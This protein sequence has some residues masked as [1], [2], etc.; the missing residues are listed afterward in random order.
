MIATK[1]EIKGAD[2]LHR[3]LLQLQKPSAIKAVIRKALR[4]AAKVTQGYAIR[5][6]P[7]KTGATQA[8]IKVRATKRSRKF[9]GMNVMIGS[10]WFKGKTFYAAFVELGHF[11]GKRRLK[12]T[13][14]V[15]RELVESVYGA[16][17]RNI[18]RSTVE[19]ENRKRIEGLHWLKNASEESEQEAV[20]VYENTLSV[21]L[22]K[23]LK[24]QKPIDSEAK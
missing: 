15:K 16:H 10:G 7:Y 8:A 1:F 9:I 19:N 23:A 13:V 20:Q 11:A 21:E 24:G 3:G 4:A 14:T 12:S 2:E 5:S 18:R 22:D 6:S 17:Y